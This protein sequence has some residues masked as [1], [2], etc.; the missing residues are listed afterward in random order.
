MSKVI[1]VKALRAKVLSGTLKLVPTT[2][3]GGL[4]YNYITI[5]FKHY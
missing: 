2:G 1:S 4:H 3:P 5:K